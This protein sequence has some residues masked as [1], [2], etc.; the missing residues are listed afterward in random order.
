[1]GKT[2]NLRRAELD[3]GFSSDDRGVSRSLHPP[4][5]SPLDVPYKLNRAIELFMHWWRGLAELSVV[6]FVRPSHLPLLLAAEQEHDSAFSLRGG[7]ART[8]NAYN[9]KT[10]SPLIAFPNILPPTFA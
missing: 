6:G 3:R 2:R 7:G 5:N 9:I 1:M 10:A 8:T 4:P